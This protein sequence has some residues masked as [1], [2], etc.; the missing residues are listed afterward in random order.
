MEKAENS[1]RALAFNL[2]D[3]GN[4]QIFKDK[5]KINVIKNLHK[6]FVLLKPNKGNGIVQIKA[7]EYYTSLEKLF[8][9]KEKFKKITE[10]PTP[11]RLATLQVPKTT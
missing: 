1:L 5:Q 4:N 6:D 11:T 8:S 9:D 10:D 7:T 2:I 3:L